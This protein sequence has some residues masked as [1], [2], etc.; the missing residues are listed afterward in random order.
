MRGSTTSFSSLTPQP[1]SQPL[2]QVS[3]FLGREVHYRVNLPL[4]E[5]ENEIDAPIAVAAE[6]IT[7]LWAY[8]PHE[9]DPLP[10]FHFTPPF[11][12]AEAE[13]GNEQ[14]RIPRLYPLRERF[15]GAG[16]V[17]RT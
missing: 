6:A 9:K 1:F 12:G 14:T 13:M 7:P 17:G 8:G 3:P 10:D 11:G 15:A 2:M 5:F 4:P 16:T